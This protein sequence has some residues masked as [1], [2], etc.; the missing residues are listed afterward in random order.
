MR[1][2]YFIQSGIKGN[3]IHRITEFHEKVKPSLIIVFMFQ[4]ALIMILDY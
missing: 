1:N 3:N 4:Q 2:G